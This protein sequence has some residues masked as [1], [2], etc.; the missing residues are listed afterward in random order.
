MYNNLG[1]LRDKRKIKIASWEEI[2]TRHSALDEDPHIWRRGKYP[3][4]PLPKEE[5]PRGWQQRGKLL[6]IL[7]REN[8]GVLEMRIY[9]LLL[10]LKVKPKC[11]PPPCTWSRSTVSELKSPPSVRLSR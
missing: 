10:T 1:S 5:H 4:Q 9:S 11:I 8:T 2:S 3:F 7:E 6:E